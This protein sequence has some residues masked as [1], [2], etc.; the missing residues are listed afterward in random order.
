ME[1]LSV[2][3]QRRVNTKAP[4]EKR[5]EAFEVVASRLVDAMRASDENKKELK[6]RAARVA[7]GE[8]DHE[9]PW[10]LFDAAW[11]EAYPRWTEVVG[12]DVIVAMARFWCPKIGAGETS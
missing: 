10:W 6:E 3:V 12:S 11:T 4:V 2:R 1:R 7:K 8:V 5:L 9:L